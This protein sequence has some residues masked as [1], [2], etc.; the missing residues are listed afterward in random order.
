MPL[1]NRQYCGT[2][3]GMSIDFGTGGPLNQSRA[4]LRDP[5]RRHEIILD[6]VE[7]NSVIEGLP[8][9]TPETREHIRRQLEA[10]SPIGGSLA[11]S[12][13]PSESAAL[14]EHNLGRTPQ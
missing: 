2:L 9:F 5:R 8:P 13:T 7:R 14:A 10:I 12:L 4:E 3:K 6:V 1:Q 11:I